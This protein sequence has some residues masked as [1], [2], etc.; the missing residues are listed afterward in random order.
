MKGMRSL[1]A[2]LLLFTGVVAIG[3]LLETVAD[4]AGGIHRHEQNV[5]GIRLRRM[6]SMPHL[7]QVSNTCGQNESQIMEVLPCFVKRFR[8][9]RSL[10]YP[11]LCW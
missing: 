3:I 8:F 7:Q 10:Q 11:S 2:A 4:I 6:W 5:S 1:V 9:S